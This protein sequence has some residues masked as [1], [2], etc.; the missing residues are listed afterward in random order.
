MGTEKKKRWKKE[1]KK[2]R[3]IKEGNKLEKERKRGGVKKDGKRKKNGKKKLDIR[4]SNL[5]QERFTLSHH[6][7]SVL[8]NSV[9]SYFSRRVALVRS[10]DNPTECIN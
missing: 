6:D 10:G 7:E 4:A 5:C 9:H 8:S 1:E 2:R 3:W